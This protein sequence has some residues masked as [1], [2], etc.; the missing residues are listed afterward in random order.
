M[1]LGAVDE[2]RRDTARALASRAQEGRAARRPR[3]Q[4]GRAAR[5]PAHGE[6]ARLARARVRARSSGGAPWVPERSSRTCRCGSPSCPRVGS[7][8]LVFRSE[9]S[10]GKIEVKRYLGAMYGMDAVARVDSANHEGKW[11]RSRAP[12]SRALMKD[13]TPPRARQEG[14]RVV[15][16]RQAIQ[17]VLGD[18][19]QAPH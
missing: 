8:T 11:R 6:G 16:A 9:Q 3:T 12:Q 5:R 17:K 4:E 7:R 2:R 10:V 14:A 18:A 19:S 1:V 13:L 15:G